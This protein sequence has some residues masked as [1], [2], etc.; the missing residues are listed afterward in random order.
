MDWIEDEWGRKTAVYKMAPDSPNNFTYPLS[1][2][3]RGYELYMQSGETSVPSIEE[4]MY[5]S[6]EW[7]NQVLLYYEGMKWAEQ[8]TKGN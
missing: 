4:A 5:K 1:L 2:I 3:A 7:E 6:N 8:T